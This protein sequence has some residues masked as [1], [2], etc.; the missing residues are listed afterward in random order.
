MKLSIGDG[1]VIIAATNLIVLH[2]VALLII[3]KYIALSQ[4]QLWLTN[5]QS[6]F[7]LFTLLLKYDVLCLN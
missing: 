1:I 3:D 6:P 4:R 5:A 7:D 2:K